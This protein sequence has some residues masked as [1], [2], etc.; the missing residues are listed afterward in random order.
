MMTIHEPIYLISV[1]HRHAPKQSQNAGKQ[2]AEALCSGRGFF[3]LRAAQAATLGRRALAQQRDKSLFRHG[4][5]EEKALAIV[6]AHADQRQC[7]GGLLD[8]DRDHV[9]AEVMGEVDHRLAQRR[10]DFVCPAIRNERSIKL[11][12]FEW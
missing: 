5:A 6:A 7:I 12:L 3:G 4:L 1:V 10:I 8:T 2:I 9:A 11:E